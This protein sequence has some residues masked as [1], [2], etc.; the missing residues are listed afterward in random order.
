[1]NHK[2]PRYPQTFY[3][4]DGWCDIVREIERDCEE[5]YPEDPYGDGED[6]PGIFPLEYTVERF[7]A[8][9]E[10]YKAGNRYGSVME[11]TDEVYALFSTIFELPQVTKREGYVPK[12]RKT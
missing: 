4:S 9:L 1:M 5:I 3:L 8:I 10:Q 7:T 2:K 6:D 12:E 11:F